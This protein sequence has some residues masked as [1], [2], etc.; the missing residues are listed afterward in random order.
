MKV[1]KAICERLCNSSESE[2]LHLYMLLYPK[3]LIAYSIY[4]SNW[5]PLRNLLMKSTTQIWHY[6]PLHKGKKYVKMLLSMT[7]KL[8]KDLPFASKHLVF[9]FTLLMS[10]FHIRV[11]IST[12][13]KQWKCESDTVPVDQL[14]S[15]LKCCTCLCTYRVLITCTASNIGNQKQLTA[16]T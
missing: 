3:V 14:L 2:E 16:V 7:V 4:S 10:H 15:L 11:L 12:A 5:Y 13:E 1:K 8:K 6:F 9:C